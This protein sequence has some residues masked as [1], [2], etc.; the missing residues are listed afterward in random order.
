MTGH[1]REMEAATI[2]PQ[3][4]AGL[5]NGA[6]ALAMCAVELASDPQLLQQVKEEFAR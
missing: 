3:G 6:S 2:S 1:A 4:R 5:E